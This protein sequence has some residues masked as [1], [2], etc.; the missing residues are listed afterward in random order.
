[1]TE[2]KRIH[3]TYA[4]FL[5]Y[6][7]VISKNAA[8]SPSC[9]FSPRTSTSE[10]DVYLGR[11]VQQGQNNDE[12]SRRVSQIINHPDYNSGTQDNDIC[13][14]RLS[15]SVSFT[16]YIKPICLAAS[17]STYA[18]GSDAWITGWGTINSDGDQNL[19]YSH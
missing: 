9:V 19:F 7:D 1:M 3:P 17:G 5:S 4:C 13:L 10:V 11:R 15:T 14:L 8:I 16:D 6:P 2:T 12:V 18:A